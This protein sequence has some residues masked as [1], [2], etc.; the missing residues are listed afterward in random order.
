[1]GSEMCIRDRLFVVA[2][3]GLVVVFTLA[4]AASGG[5]A[6]ACAAD[7]PSSSLKLSGLRRPLGSSRALAAFA[8]LSVGPLTRFLAAALALMRCAGPKA[9]LGGE[10][11]V[12]YASS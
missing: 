9:C 10:L 12:E 8:W 11:V 3:G 5:S 4:A 1:M 7:A 6:V 2:S